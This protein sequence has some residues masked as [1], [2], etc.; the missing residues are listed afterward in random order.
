MTLVGVVAYYLSAPT[1]GS[2]FARPV[3]RRI[4]SELQP[5]IAPTLAVMHGWR[6]A[7]RARTA[8]AGRADH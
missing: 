8:L 3:T 5:L 4:R 1:A 6:L 2:A 7:K